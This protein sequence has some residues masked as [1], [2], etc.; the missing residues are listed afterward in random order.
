MA[1]SLTNKEFLDRVYKLVGDEYS[2]LSD[3]ISRHDKV[4]MKH[5]V[6]GY[7][8]DVESGA[9]LGNKNKK[10]SR[11]P[12]C[13]G[14]IN[15][16]TKIFS[17]E[18]NKSTKGTYELVGEY[19]NAHTKVKIKH[20]LC[21]NTY[22]CFPMSFTAGT[23]C[24]YC[25]NKRID[26]AEVSKRVYKLTNGQYK[27]NSDYTGVFNK[28]EL[29][30]VN[31]GSKVYTTLAKLDEKIVPTCKKCNPNSYGEAKIQVAL[32]VLKISYEQQKRFKELPKLSYDFYLPDYNIL[33]EYQGIQH[34]QPVKF[35][36]G[37]KAF[38]NQEIIDM[39]KRNFAKENSY[40]LIEIPYSIFDNKAIENIIVNYISNAETPKPKIRSMI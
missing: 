28:L 24:P 2:V 14:N 17:N 36:G 40:L 4:S 6:C 33:I 31:C 32:D 34:Y 18:V 5:N 11:C 38:K 12:K 35:F 9:F 15:K 27:L 7:V 13:Y 20:L 21:N 1:K 8:W 3:Y 25:A 22:F 16:T 29:I 10:G 39:N 26:N 23:R 19:K 37:E 30:H